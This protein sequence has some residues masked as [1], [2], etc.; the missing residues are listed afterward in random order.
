MIFVSFKRQPLR[1]HSPRTNLAWKELDDREPPELATLSQGFRC[2]A[3]KF[4]SAPY[5]AHVPKLVFLTVEV[6]KRRTWGENFRS[7][8]RD[9]NQHFLAARQCDFLVS[10][11]GRG[12]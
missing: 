9:A 6:A 11:E 12:S 3:S 10:V 8:R 2:K 4:A 1:S 7:V 5:L